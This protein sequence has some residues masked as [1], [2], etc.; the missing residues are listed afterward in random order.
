MAM[1]YVNC[2]L[3][4]FLKLDKTLS[5]AIETHMYTLV[6]IRIYGHVQNQTIM[7][8]QLPSA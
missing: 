3:S 6:A 5:F 8:Q 1:L 2:L 7:I 4:P